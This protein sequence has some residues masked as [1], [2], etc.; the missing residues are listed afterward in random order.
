M[1]QDIGKELHTD[2]IYLQIGI[3]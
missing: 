3:L 2:Y 1:N